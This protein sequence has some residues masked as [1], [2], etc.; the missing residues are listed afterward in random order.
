MGAS[1]AGD[2]REPPRPSLAGADWLSWPQTIKVFN[3]LN[4]EGFEAR[5]VGGAVRNTLLGRPV[6]DI[7]L[8]TT[9]RPE[10]V[11][12]LAGEAGLKAIPTGVEHGTVTLVSDGTPFE[13]TTLRADVETDGRRAVVAFTDDWAADASRRDFT[14]NA[15]YADARGCVHDPVG[16]LPDLLALRVRFIGDPALRIRED[17]LR[18]LRFF[19]FSADYSGGVLDAA[20]LS[21]CIAACAGLRTLSRERIRAELL[22]LL[23]ASHAVPVIEAMEDSGILADLLG[24]VTMRARLARLVAIETALDVTPGAMRRLAALAVLVAEDAE[25]L[26]ERL[27]LSRAEASELAAMADPRGFRRRLSEEGAPAL[28]YRIGKAAFIDNLLIAWA[29]SG[30][31]VD[32]PLWRALYHQAEQWQAPVLPVSGGDLLKAGLAPGPDVGAALR[33]LEQDWVESGFRLSRDDLLARLDR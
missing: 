15:L 27:R 20:G 16:G 25:R 22:K 21:A 32:A 2:R 26:A 10:D 14:L 4:R 29:G 11:I 28:L 33:A 1:N 6:T 5:A 3:A 12:R 17:Y 31:P 8:A 19:R 7:D 13:V 30:E 18:I 9:A 23:V 24:G